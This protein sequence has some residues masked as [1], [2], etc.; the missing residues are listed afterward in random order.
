LNRPWENPDVELLKSI[1]TL[2]A[3]GGAESGQLSER[4][5][6]TKAKGKKVLPDLATK[7]EPGGGGSR[8]ARPA[9]DIAYKTPPNRRLSNMISAGEKKIR[10]WNFKLSDLKGRPQPHMLP[11]STME[12]G[13][14]H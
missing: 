5:G 7:Q 3:C 12:P 14:R 2:P 9:S 11:F 8:G 4:V 10:D 6:V 13:T 1:F